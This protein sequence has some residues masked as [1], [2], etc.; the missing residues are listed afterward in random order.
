MER[1]RAIIEA[2]TES[3]TVGPTTGPRNRFDETR[4]SFTWRA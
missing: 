4:V 2:V 3:L 1:Q